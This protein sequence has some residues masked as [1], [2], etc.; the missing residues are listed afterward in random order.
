MDPERFSF[1]YDKTKSEIL[2]KMTDINKDSEYNIEY[3]TL[4]TKEFMTLHEIKFKEMLGIMDDLCYGEINYELVQ[5][6]TDY[7]MIP[8]LDGTG[9][10][11]K[12]SFHME[13]Y[14]EVNKKSELPQYEYTFSRHDNVFDEL[15][16]LLPKRTDLIKKLRDII[17]D[18][19][20]EKEKSIKDDP[21][22][23]Y[24][25]LVYTYISYMYSLHYMSGDTYTTKCKYT[26]T[27]TYWYE[28]D[29]NDGTVVSDEDIIKQREIIIKDITYFAK[30]FKNNGEDQECACQKIMHRR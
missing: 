6:G 5:E 8:N 14:R 3:T 28:Y 11:R 22:N 7:E 17:K 30:I 26:D 27:S 19:K 21:V 23:N 9:I 12:L 13:K 15:I 20:K 25:L 24:E 18:G 29:M 16:N 10:E 4:I 2:L 1:T